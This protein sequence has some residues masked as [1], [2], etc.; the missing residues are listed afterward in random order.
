MSKRF[1]RRDLNVRYE[2]FDHYALG[3]QRN[4]YR[5]TRDS[6]DKASQQVNFIRALFAFLTGFF[7]ATA[8]LIVQAYFTESGACNA[9]DPAS[10]CS[11]L[12]TAVQ[13][14]VI[15]SVVTPA[16]GAFFNSLSDLFQWSRTRTIYDEALEAIRVADALSPLP[17][18]TN[19]AY[20]EQLLD[21]VE[22]VLSV[23]SDETAQ[24]GQSI[25]EPEQMKEFI[26][27][28]RQIGQSVGG[29]ANAQE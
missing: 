17:E 28:Q 19:K 14:M 4:Y 26:K 8:A 3:D 7:S 16:F 22:S 2:V 11:G 27:A 13:A 25:R 6:N 9:A 10:F 12:S 21:Y 5:K 15:L 20:E 23:M 1:D 24:W 29:D 18:M